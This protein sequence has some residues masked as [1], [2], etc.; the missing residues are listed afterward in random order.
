MD[1]VSLKGQIL[2]VRI[3][4]M[5][6]FKLAQFKNIGIFLLKDLKR[7]PVAS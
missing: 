2:E 7:I 3:L 6:K 1:M 4:L 5:K